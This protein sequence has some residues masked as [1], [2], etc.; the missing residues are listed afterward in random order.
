M[1]RAQDRYLANALG[2]SLFFDRTIEHQAEL[3]RQV[4]AL[5]PGDIQAALRRHIDPAKITVVLAGDFGKAE[6]ET[7]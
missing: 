5:T 1:N 3:E 2:G 6:S 7:R 4:A